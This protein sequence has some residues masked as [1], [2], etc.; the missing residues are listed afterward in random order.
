MIVKHEHFDLLDKMIIERMIFHSPLK[1]S[2]VMQNETCFLHVRSGQSRLHTADNTLEVRTNDCLVMQC[3]TYL[4]NWFQ[5][6][7]ES[8]NEAIAIHFYPDV[9]AYVFDGELPKFLE[10]TSIGASPVQ[11]IKADKM[12][13]NYIESL[14]FYFDNPSL[15]TEE[16]TKLKLKELILLLVNS[17]NGDQLKALLGGFYQPHQ[18][19]FKQIIENHLFSDLLL[20]DLAFI[21]G[22]S[23]S[24][25]KRKF[26]E[27]YKT[28]PA[29]YIKLER[30]KK[31]KELLEKTNLRISEI[32]YDCGFNDLGYFSKS[33]NAYYKVSPSKF[34][35]NSL[36]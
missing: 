31:A 20:E 23:L 1:S 34:R 8:P 4:N 6:K 7:S 9:L 11:K 10:N 33:F 21:T 5:T 24:S 29:K 2:S 36:N 17:S 19:A 3:G 18:I 28:S 15:V 14:L 26:K 27:I 30:L 25:F 16:L 22:M 12:I 35:E 32:A 13:N